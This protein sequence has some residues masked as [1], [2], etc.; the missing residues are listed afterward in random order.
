M[1]QVTMTCSTDNIT[2]RIAPFID[3]V[4][5]EYLGTAQESTDRFCTSGNGLVTLSPN[6]TVELHVRNQEGTNNVTSFHLNVTL[7]SIYPYS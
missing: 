4:A 6:S 3:G 5:Q 2:F 1:Y 7:V